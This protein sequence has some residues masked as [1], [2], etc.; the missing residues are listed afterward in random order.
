MSTYRC[1]SWRAISNAAHRPHRH[2]STA[3][4]R[5]TAPHWT[6][7][8]ACEDHTACRTQA[9][10]LD[11]HNLHVAGR[12]TR[13]QHNPGTHQDAATCTTPCHTH[14]MH[15]CTQVSPDIDRSI[16]Q[17][18]VITRADK[19]P[20][21]TGQVSLVAQSG[22]HTRQNAHS[23][24]CTQGKPCTQPARQD[25][26]AQ[27]DGGTPPCNSSRPPAGTC[28][29]TPAGKH[30]ATHTTQE[31][32]REKQRHSDRHRMMCQQSEHTAGRR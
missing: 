19:Q 11:R 27:H 13:H 14:A 2:A 15:V 16:N 20:V 8:H 24:D 18:I 10:H 29:G 9:D 7:A 31:S 3:A 25:A 4:T 26:N 21:G 5:R 22:H 12:T 6:H 23:T 32:T 17:S 1:V 30:S 28:R